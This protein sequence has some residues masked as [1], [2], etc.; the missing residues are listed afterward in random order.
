[1]T[2]YAPLSYDVD[3]GHQGHQYVAA[4]HGVGEGAEDGP[5]K[6]S[7]G[8]WDKEY[9]CPSMSALM[10]PSIDWGGDWNKN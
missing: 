1:M 6:C 2:L 3:E 7:S 9:S 5:L 4:V 10:A 8:G